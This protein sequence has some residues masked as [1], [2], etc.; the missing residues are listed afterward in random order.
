MSRSSTRTLVAAARIA[1]E[2]GDARYVEHE[3]ASRLLRKVRDAQQVGVRGAGTTAPAEA[4][5]DARDRDCGVALAQL[6]GSAHGWEDSAENDRGG[7][8]V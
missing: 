1:Y 4:L 5:R 2:S 6:I 3:V 7:P 8:D